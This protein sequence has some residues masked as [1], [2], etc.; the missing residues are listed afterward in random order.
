MVDDEWDGLLGDSPFGDMLNFYASTN[1]GYAIWPL[2]EVC[3]RKGALFSSPDAF[4][5]GRPVNSTLPDEDIVNLKDL[6]PEYED[7]GLT[8]AH[9]AWHVI[10][11]SGDLR[12]FFDKAPYP[13]PYVLWQRDGVGKLRRYKFN[14]IKR[15]I[16]G[17][18]T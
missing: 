16:H 4:I 7:I 2:M 5:M 14:T 9:D 17:Q 18:H 1:G 15:K 3:G 11:A 8:D 10:Y 13:L 6:H 12:H